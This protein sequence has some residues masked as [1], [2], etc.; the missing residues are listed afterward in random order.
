[1]TGQ[2]SIN[3]D[4]TIGSITILNESI[5][6]VNSDTIKDEQVNNLFIQE[7]E[8]ELSS[9]C[10]ALKMAIAK[11]N[12]FYG[13][14]VSRRGEEI[15]KL[16]IEIARKIL[17]QKIEAKDYEIE[18]IIKEALKNSPSNHDIVVHLNPEDYIQFQDVMKKDAS[19]LP[20][21]VTFI[22]D[23]NVGCAECILK[24]TKGTIISLINDQLEQIENALKKTQ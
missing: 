24:T 23:P 5:E 9:A 2:I 20:P 11:V 16:S 15:A 4:N 14:I 7:K 1:M 18:S 3:L 19:V 6:P 10:N 13:N 22:A 12:K 8:K 21:G 17:A